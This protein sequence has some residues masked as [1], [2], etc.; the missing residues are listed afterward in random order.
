MAPRTTEQNSRFFEEYKYCRFCDE[1]DSGGRSNSWPWLCRLAGIGDRPDP[2]EKRQEVLQHLYSRMNKSYRAKVADVENAAAGVYAIHADCED[3]VLMEKTLESL[4]R[5]LNDTPGNKN[6]V[7]LKI[8]MAVYD[9]MYNIY[10]QLLPGSAER[11][12]HILQ[13]MVR[14]IK[15]NEAGAFDHNP[16]YITAKRIEYFMGGIPAQK[17]YAL[18]LEINRKTAD[19]E[20][21]D[22]R[23]RLETLAAEYKS[24]QAKQRLEKIEERQCRYEQ[25]RSSDLPKAA[26]N[27]TRISLYNELLGLINTQDWSRGRKFNEKK[28]VYNHLIPLYQAEGMYDEAFHA[29]AERDKFLNAGKICREAAK[30]RG[31]GRGA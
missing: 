11:R 26:D 31:Y 9:N 24:E 8:R 25:I 2:G 19:R 23:R 28:S 15:N 12:F 1:Y 30:A 17:R 27:R 18:L 4:G 13:K 14:E 6:S 29:E 7:G 20:K 16:L 22:Y 10:E 21:Y 5:V 3:V